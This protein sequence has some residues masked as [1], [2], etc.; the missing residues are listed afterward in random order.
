MSSKTIRVF[1]YGTLKA[2]HPNH[3]PME[4]QKFLGRALLR[5]K[6]RFVNCGWYP[7]VVKD[8]SGEERDIGGEV[9]EIEGDILNT[10]DMIEGHPHYYC[11]EKVLTPYGKAWVY[12]L[13]AEEGCRAE[14]SEVFWKQSE[15]E[16]KWYANTSM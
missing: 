15:E 13:P 10:L 1:V 5:G 12:M 9:Y 16:G 2:G 14:V 6:Y 7:A 4:K 8:P 3:G 11:R